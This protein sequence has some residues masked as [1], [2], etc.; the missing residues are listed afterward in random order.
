M[1]LQRKGF[2]IKDAG[3]FL[4]SDDPYIGVSPDRTVCCDC[5]GKGVLEVECPFGMKD[6]LPPDDKENVFMELKNGKW[7]LK[8]DHAYFYQVQTQFNV[9]QLPYADFVVW[10]K[11][12]VTFEWIPEKPSFQKYTQK[13]LNIFSYTVFCL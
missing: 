4:H 12:G 7:I 10:T 5:H 11:N 6:G 13:P 8:N 2:K 3:L 9:C 1:E